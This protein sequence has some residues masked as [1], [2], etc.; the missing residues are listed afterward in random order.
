MYVERNQMSEVQ[1]PSASFELLR[2]MMT[3]RIDKLI[4]YSWWP[5]EESVVKASIGSN[6]VFSLTAGPLAIVFEDG[7]VV[8]VSSDPTLSSVIL[9]ADEKDNKSLTSDES[10]R[11]IEE[12]FPV[13]NTDPIYSKN[14]WADISQSI[15]V[16]YELLKYK[17]MNSIQL[18]RPSERGLRVLLNTGKSFILSHG[19]HDYSDD[20]SVIMDD[21]LDDFDEVVSTPLM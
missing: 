8:G 5:A 4:R 9:W 19:M 16:G 10:L 12:L 21:Q 1:V 11:E 13:L 17:N 15:I 20:F 18:D 14:F 6:E 2:Y 7:Y 3:K